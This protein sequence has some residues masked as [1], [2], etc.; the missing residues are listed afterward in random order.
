[1][2]ALMKHDGRW[3][4]KAHTMNRELRILSGLHRGALLPL[5]L[6]S[7]LTIGSKADCDIVLV[8]P[9]IKPLE[10]SVELSAEGWQIERFNAKGK[11]TD[12]QCIPWGQAEI[13]GGVVLTVVDAAQPWVFI[14][15]DEV[16]R[17]QQLDNAK[18]LEAAAAVA[19]GAGVIAPSEAPSAAPVRPKNRRKLTQRL[20]ISIAIIFGFATFSISRAVSTSEE[21][22]SKTESLHT[23]ILYS[24]A[25]S[26]EKLAAAKLP[27]KGGTDAVGG[28][29]EPTTEASKAGLEKPSPEQL[30]ALLI[31]KLRDAYLAEK[32]D[33]DLTN[34]EWHLRGLLDEE[35]AQ[36]FHRILSNFY[37]EHNVKIPLNANVN[38]P[39]ELLPFRI[40]QF[41]SGAMSSVVT[42]DGQ[43]LYVGD[44]YMGFTLQRIEGRRM[45]FAG[46]RKVEVLW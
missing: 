16:A 42:D 20:A 10:L 6:G 27:V 7:R 17:A 46:K 18:K 40:Q 2:Q 32:L 36:R 37:K 12:K 28:A 23:E 5:Q 45:T 1:M 4:L 3:K 21:K 33:I 31:Q 15:A 22:T 9:G 26:K 35:E 24:N 39:E 8:D 29:M 34:S 38:S 43:R 14:S 41:N 25:I 11:P 44:S 30:R 19:Q 13:V